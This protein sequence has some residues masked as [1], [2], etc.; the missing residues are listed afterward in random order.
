MDFITHLPWPT[1][2]FG[3][4]DNQKIVFHI[5][6]S[7][8]AL[9][10]VLM[11]SLKFIFLF[12]ITFR[13]LVFVSSFSIFALIF[14][15]II[16]LVYGYTTI[17]VHIDKSVLMPPSWSALFS[18]MGVPAFSLGYNFSFLS[19]YVSVLIDCD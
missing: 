13:P 11:S 8:L 2:L 17:G 4:A 1:T 12:I 16:L 3:G 5:L 6:S 7:V 10:L 15:F 9:I 19:F 14:S 18:S